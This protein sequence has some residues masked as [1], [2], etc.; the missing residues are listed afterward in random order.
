MP[1]LMRKRPVHRDRDLAAVG[2]G[3]APD[4]G[5]REIRIDEA[6][7]GRR[8]P[9]AIS[10]SPCSARYVGAAQ[11]TVARGGELARDERRIGERPD[12]HRDVD[13]FLDQVHEAVVEPQVERDLADGRART[14]AI[15]GPRCRMPKDIG[16]LTRRRPRGSDCSCATAPSASSMRSIAPRL[17][18]NSAAPASV[19]DR[20]AR[21]AVQQARAQA[22]LQARDVLAHDR[23]R[24]LE[25]V[26][27]EREA[28][29]L[30]HAHEHRDVGEAGPWISSFP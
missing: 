30:H 25:L 23:A 1:L 5:G 19:S 6:V 4:V 2:R 26:G 13:A 21:R 18:S 3:E 20:P 7:V 14:R 24:E 15:A 11:A 17:A 8:G 12:A 29:A 10:G 9:R 22:L 16:A 27:G 28:A